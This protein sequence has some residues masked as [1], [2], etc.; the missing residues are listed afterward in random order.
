MGTVTVEGGRYV[1]EGAFHQIEGGTPIQDGKGTLCGVTKPRNMTYIHSYGGEAP[2]FQAVSEKGRLL[3]T[4]CDN[5][6][7]P[8]KGTIYLPFRIACPDCLSQNNVVDLTDKANEVA[9]IYTY[10]VTERSGAFNTLEKPIRFVDIEFPGTGVRT[11]LKGYMV[12]PGQPSIGLRMVPVFRTGKPSYT[13]QD[14]AWAV[15]GTKPGEL[16]EGFTFSL[17]A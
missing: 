1:P 2:F 13:I 6:A 7:C 8:G 10:I 16:P 15:A 14:L 4:R 3:A 9:R 5:P 11:L 17:P 12:G